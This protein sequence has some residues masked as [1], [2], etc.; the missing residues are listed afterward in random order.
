MKCQ[1]QIRM[2]V[3]SG[4]CNHEASDEAASGLPVCNCC[5]VLGPLWEEVQ[6]EVDAHI[7]AA[8]ERGRNSGLIHV[9]YTHDRRIKVMEVGPP[10]YN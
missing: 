1:N 6:R 5:M 7:E 8:A 4:P 9:V 3:Q 2:G 10:Q